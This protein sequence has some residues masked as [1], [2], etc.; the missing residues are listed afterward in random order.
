MVFIYVEI[1]LTDFPKKK[2]CKH[3]SLWNILVGTTGSLA[4]DISIDP[5]MNKCVMLLLLKQME[6]IVF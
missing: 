1:I 2:D 5:R 4:S 3:F 6:A